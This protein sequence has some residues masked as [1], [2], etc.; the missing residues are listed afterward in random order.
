M[1]YEVFWSRLAQDAL[2]GL[3]KSL[4]GRIVKKTVAISA[5][6]HPFLEKLTDI[7]CYKLRIGDYRAFIDIDEQKQELHVLSVRHRKVAYK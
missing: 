1:P 7:K 2:A 4:A 5:N 6:P 3:E